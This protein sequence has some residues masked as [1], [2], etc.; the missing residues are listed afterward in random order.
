MRR[1][2]K[3]IQVYGNAANLG[4]L[5]RANKRG[6]DPEYRGGNIIPP[7]KTFSIGIRAQL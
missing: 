6:I 7:S 4:I 1:A 3:S 2:F 5:W